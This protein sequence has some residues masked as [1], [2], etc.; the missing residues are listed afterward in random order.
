MYPAG[1]S[2]RPPTTFS[3]L[4]ARK[5]ELSRGPACPANVASLIRIPLSPG[6]IAA[7]LLGD[8]RAPDA[9]VAVVDWDPSRGADVLALRE[10]DGGALL[11]YFHGPT[12]ELVAAVRTGADGSRLWQTAYDTWETVGGVRLPGRIRFAE[13]NESFDD[14][15]DLLFKDRTLNQ[16][17]P[18]GAFTLAPPPGVAVKDVGCGG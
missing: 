8:V 7:V 11:L 17:P 4:D 6:D 10:R 3:L 5:N 16:P 13:H 9:P 12:H 14:G 15:V 1:V 18:P 2:D